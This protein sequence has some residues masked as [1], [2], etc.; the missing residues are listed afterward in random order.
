MTST[1][2][3]K[4]ETLVPHD[5]ATISNYVTLAEKR[6]YL[7]AGARRIFAFSSSHER[8]LNFYTVSPLTKSRAPRTL[9]ESIEEACA[10][11]IQAI[12]SSNRDFLYLGDNFGHN[13][14][15]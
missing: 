9:Q 14:H 12:V 3:G 7:L 13:Y 6:Y 1:F 5:L 4:R 11:R 10:L 2:S 15:I 8:F